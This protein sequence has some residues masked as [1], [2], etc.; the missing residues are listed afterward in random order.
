MAD[1]T[2]APRKGAGMWGQAVAAV[3]VVAALCVGLWMFGKTSSSDSDLRPATCSGGDSEK[4]PGEPGK[5][6]RHVSGAQLCEALNRPDLAEL[7]GAPGKTAKTAAGSAG[8]VK[9]A[10]GEEIATPSAQVEL[11]TYTVA[12]SASYDRLPVAGSTALVRE[13]TRQQTV[14]GRPAVFYS[15]RTL[16]IR[17]RL[18]GSDTGSGP[19]VP[20]RALTVAREAKDSGGSF[21]VVL[22]RAD[23]E[24]PDD[25][26][27]LRVAEKVLPT[28]PGWAAAS[29]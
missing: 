19:G 2:G 13:G 17:F 14:L 15:D 8:S 3:A 4:A 7:L 26:V 25:A 16:S 10:N 18:D 12:L 5:A 23:G 28:V 22:W 20:A 29:R 27:L 6:P 9:L 11:G 24:V 1:D 21:E